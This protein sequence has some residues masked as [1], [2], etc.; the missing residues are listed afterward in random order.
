MVMTKIELEIHDDV[1]STINKI[2][3][4]NDSG[5]DLMIPQG[6]VLF[7]SILNLKLLDSFGKKLDKTVHFNTEDEQGGTL[8]EMLDATGAQGELTGRTVRETEDPLLLDIEQETAEK[9]R[10]AKRKFKIGNILQKVKGP[11]IRSKGIL[12]LIAII[13][14]LVGGTY[15][16]IKFLSKKPIATAKIY[17][18]AQPLTRSVTIKISA[19]QDTNVEEKVLHGNTIETS[20]TQTAEAETTGERLEGEKSRGTVTIYNRTTEEIKLKKGKELEFDDEDDT[21]VFKLKEELTIPPVSLEDPEDPS[22]G[23]IPGQ[24]EGAL[25]ATDIGKK[26]NVGKEETLEV[27]DYKKAD[28]VAETKGN[29]EGGSSEEIKVVSEQDIETLGTALNEKLTQEVGRALKNTV[30]KGNTFV[31]GSETETSIEEE[32]SHE[33]GEKTENV[34]LSKTAGYNGL[35]YS[36][37][38]LETFLDNIVAELVPDGFELHKED[39]ET[40]VDILGDSTDSILSA[41]EADVQV[42]LK[43]SIVPKHNIEEIRN[44]IMGKSPTEAQAILGSLSNIKTYEITLAPNVPFF[45]NVPNEKD[46]VIVEIVKE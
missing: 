21:L 5:I 40:K 26:Y 37:K 33:L 12:G 34:E 29:F 43:T 23:L 36:H 16:G 28:L 15:L 6:S 20:V 38:E 8:I 25:E 30:S 13:L 22:S 4:V 44:S 27:E 7:D 11:R 14:L 41:T 31:E 39:R 42:T 45:G 32:L 19:V 46:R 24:A 9:S 17:I 18:D 1:V 3:N 10:Y 35:A 2:R